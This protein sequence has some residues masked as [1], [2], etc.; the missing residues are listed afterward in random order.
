MLFLAFREPDLE[1][2]ASARVM[3]INRHEC[4]AGAL[5][6]AD[7]F[8][9]FG[10]VEQELPRACRIRLNVRRCARQWADVRAEQKEL[11]VAHYYV[12]FFQLRAP[13]ANRFYLPPFQGD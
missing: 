13:C 11:A 2:D 1:L 9:D 3:H 6:G 8:A 7:Q 4:I 5:Y 12:S 10:R